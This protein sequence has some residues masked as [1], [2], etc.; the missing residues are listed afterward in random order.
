VRLSYSFDVNPG[1]G[2]LRLTLLNDASATAFAGDGSIAADVGDVA[3]SFRSFSTPLPTFGAIQQFDHLVYP[4]GN[5]N[6]PEGSDLSFSAEVWLPAAPLLADA[7]VMNVN[8]ATRSD[9]QIN[10]FVSPQ[11]GAAQF[12]GLQGPTTAWQLSSSQALNDGNL[13][14][15]VASVGPKSASLTVDGTSVTGKAAP[16]DT[17]LLDR[18]EI[19]IATNSSGPLT[20]IVRHLRIAPP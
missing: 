15:L 20:G 2:R 6:L 8:F 13:H 11:A 18:I 9:Q 12:E 4:A 10:L 14:A 7:A 16:Y 1:A 17:S 3:L 19:G 5:G